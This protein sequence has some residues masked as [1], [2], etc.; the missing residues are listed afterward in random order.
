MDRPRV[1]LHTLGCPKNDADSDSLSRR[2]AAERVAV[3]AHPE[4]A[5]HILVNTCGFTQEA[6]E[7]SIA[8]ILEAKAAY[9]E[10]ELLVMGCLVERYRTELE[11]GLPEVQGWFGLGDR[12]VLLERLRRPGSSEDLGAIAPP[13]APARTFAYVKISDGCDHPCSFCAIPGIK[14]PYRG[15]DPDTILREAAAALDEGARELVLVG[16]DTALWPEDGWRLPDLV[17]TAG[18]RCPGPLA[19]PALLPAG[20]R[21]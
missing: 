21:G 20:A 17:G 19:A 5:T 18:G 7:E 11:A 3:V 2:L 8:A 15:I 13:S 4:E 16:Q 6:K 10:T 14:G 1:Y 12:P 9:P